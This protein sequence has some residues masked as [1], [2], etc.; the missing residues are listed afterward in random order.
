MKFNHENSYFWMFQSEDFTVEYD[1]TDNLATGDTI[2]T[3]TISI[4]NSEG[5][6]LTSTMIANDSETNTEVSFT[7]QNPPSADVYEIKIIATTM[8]SKNHVAK[9]ICDVFESI[10]LNEKLADPSA[11]SYLSLKEANDYIRNIRGYPNKWDTLSIEGRKRVL[12]QACKDIDKFNFIGKKYYDFQSLEFPRDNH[13]VI[14]GD[15]GTPITITSFKNTSFTSDT[16]GSYKSNTNYWTKGTIHIT[17]AT[18][19]GDIRQISTS[20]ITTDVVTVTASF[21]ATPT[22]NSDFIAFE[23]LDEKIKRAQCIQALSIIE[24][25]GGSALQNY[26]SIGAR[27]VQI[28]DV[29][30]E[31]GGASTGAMTRKVNSEAKQLLSEWIERYRKLARA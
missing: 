4:V 23:P 6:D 13:D 14:T 2:A 24:S 31:F 29:E 26:I 17:S 11:N 28:G 7:I 5:T 18:P 1:F 20:N 27:R 8:N 12:I 3:S 25:D 10:T 15:V 9:I 22:T 21:S 16:Y 19:L 30:V